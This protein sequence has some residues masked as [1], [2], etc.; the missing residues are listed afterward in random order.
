MVLFSEESFQD[1]AFG[2]VLL[3]GQLNE[4]IPAFSPDYYILS[5]YTGNHYKLISYKH[6][7]IF[8]F[9][10]IPYGV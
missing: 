7:F 3:C 1:G 4:E 10:E 8:G 2:N 5:C 6:K 9:E